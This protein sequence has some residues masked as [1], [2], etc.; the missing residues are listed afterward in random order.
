MADIRTSEAAKTVKPLNDGRWGVYGPDG[1][2]LETFDTNAE[3]WRWLD[4][5]S[6]SAAADETRYR[7]IR[8]AFGD[9]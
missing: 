8:T 5:N 1:A 2:L 9:R 7:R 3:A 4:R 6:S